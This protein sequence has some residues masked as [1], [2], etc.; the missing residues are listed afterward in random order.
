MTH[1]H[2]SLI[3]FLVSHNPDIKLNQI[4]NKGETP[5]HIA[6]KKNNMTLVKKLLHLEAGSKPSET[7]PVS[8]IKQKDKAMEDLV[9]NNQSLEGPASISSSKAK[10]KKNSSDTLHI[11]I[12]DAKED[13]V[14]DMFSNIRNY[15]RQDGY[16]SPKNHLETVEVKNSSIMDLYHTDLRGSVSTNEE[17]N[18]TASEIAPEQEV[19]GVPSFK[20]KKLK[21]PFLSLTKVSTE[22]ASENSKR[23]KY[24]SDVQ[25]D[26]TK[27]SREAKKVGPS[28]FK[29]IKLLGV[30]SFG[31]VFL[32]EKIDSGK[33]YAMKILKKDKI[34]S[35]NLTKYAV[36][37]RNVL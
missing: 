29:V 24:G 37:E 3:N 11:E 4:N 30:G 1:N 16:L 23:S 35:R 21:K 33:L 31:E 14:D 6:T 15:F 5:A 13:V 2:P 9:K 28:S 32:V 10:L 17:C 7:L 22:S 25:N 18:V 34:F 27:T 8:K 26:S 20:S 19:S 12:E 36:V